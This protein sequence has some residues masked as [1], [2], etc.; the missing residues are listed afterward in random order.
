M[1]QAMFMVL[2]AMDKNEIVGS[3]QIISCKIFTF[4]IAS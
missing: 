1:E 3:P 2:D 4:L